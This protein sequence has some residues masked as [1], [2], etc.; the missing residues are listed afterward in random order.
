MPQDKI[1]TTP[2]KYILMAT[3]SSTTS[4]S[5]FSAGEGYSINQNLKFKLHKKPVGTADGFF[6]L[7]LVFVW[8]LVSNLLP[9]LKG[10]SDL[11]ADVDLSLLGLE[12]GARYKRS[13]GTVCNET[14]GHSLPGG[15]CAVGEKC[16]NLNS[17]L[18]T[19]YVD[20]TDGCSLGGNVCNVTRLTEASVEGVLHNGHRMEGDDLC[21]LVE[22]LVDVAASHK[23][24]NRINEC[25]VSC[26]SGRGRDDVSAALG[27]IVDYLGVIVDV[28]VCGVVNVREGH[29]EL[30]IDLIY[31]VLE[32]RVNEACLVSLG[33]DVAVLVSPL[34]L[35]EDMYLGAVNLEVVDK[36][37]ERDIGIGL[38]VAEDHC[39]GSACLACFLEASEEGRDENGVGVHHYL[40]L[41]LGVPP[42]LSLFKILARKLAYSVAYLFILEGYELCSV[43]VELRCGI[44]NYVFHFCISPLNLF[45]ILP[46]FR[47]GKH[48]ER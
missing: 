23:L 22:P 5:P 34:V 12:H 31:E 26:P 29:T 48:F 39:E 47:Q 17:L 2:V 16:V 36:L 18:S 42:C 24:G 32:H 8:I 33:S 10:S 20:R 30:R 45:V 28:C 15:E 11:V 38:G 14:A 6:M 1:H 19:H 41:K 21:G 3:S 27:D 44:E 4:W 35:C 13:N 9:A 37:C 46:A 7:F 25:N 40:D 43:E